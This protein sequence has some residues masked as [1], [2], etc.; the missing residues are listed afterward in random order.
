M[1][2]EEEATLAVSS[3][4]FGVANA[5]LELHLLLADGSER[6]LSFGQDCMS[7]A[8]VC[9]EGDGWTAEVGEQTVRFVGNPTSPAGQW[10]GQEVREALL[11]PGES[12]ELGGTRIWLVDARRPE[13]ASLDSH[14]GL[15]TSRHW[16]LRPQAYRVGRRTNT[17]HNHVEIAHP[18]VSRAQATLL[19]AEQ[20][21]F[22]LLAE[23]STTAV[24]GRL[25]EVNEVALLHH[26][27]LI[28]VG[29]VSLRFRQTGHEAAGKKT[30]SVNC[31]GGFTLQ[32]GELVL[33]ETAWKV[34]KA[35]WLLA[36]LAWAWGHP[37]SADL[38]MELLWPELPA[39][40]G[41]KNLSQC[42][43]SLKQTL[44]LREDEEDL[45]L[46]TPA[47]LQ[48]NPSLL[49]DHDAYLV[50]KLAEGQEP[51][52]WAKALDLYRGPYLPGN[53]EE[54]AELIRQELH[55]LVVGCALRLATHYAQAENWSGSATAAQRGLGLDG[56][57]EGLA[58]LLMEVSL[59]AGRFDQ[60]VRCF[61]TVRKQLQ[62]E[63]GVEPST[64]L[65]RLY[66]R[67]KLEL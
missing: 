20:G 60:A 2:S 43:G 58:L 40:R 44:Q 50:K 46:R 3:Q 10:Q 11:G 53:F 39:L 54:W 23:S 21:R 41:R 26:G 55:D 47:S 57:N 9:P 12:L 27:D 66:H 32:W 7:L 22:A 63:L 61:E 59:K 51:V 16:P 13:S 30:L 8:G 34:E 1:S 33:A 29:D 48:L 4:S 38:V 49:A 52:G 19:P 36:R 25:L 35:R 62:S 14:E 65:L 17:R 42:L 56:C 67:A 15:E 31:L 18:T 64:E 28:K 45:I 37:V 24:N 5:Y 6:W